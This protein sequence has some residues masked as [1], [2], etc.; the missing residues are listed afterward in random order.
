VAPK[1]EKPSLAG[2]RGRRIAQATL[3][4]VAAVF[5]VISTWELGRQVFGY[6]ST[7]PAVSVTCAR[8]L[9]GFE[10]ALDHGGQAPLDGVERQCVAPGDY[11]AFV[12][13]K[14][15]GEAAV[16]QRDDDRANLARYRR[17]VEMRIGR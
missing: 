16:S 5:I 8:A 4:V 13:A 2:R 3:T 6:E 11:E 12:A 9:E 10:Q 14:R 7:Y 17:A 1:I 15:L